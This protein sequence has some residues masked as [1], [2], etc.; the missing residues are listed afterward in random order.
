MNL[1]TKR[2]LLFFR[3]FGRRDHS[4]RRMHAKFAWRLAG[5]ATGQVA[6][7]PDSLIEWWWKVQDL[8]PDER[9]GKP[10]SLEPPDNPQA[11]AAER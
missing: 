9:S 5:I 7:M 8:L 2:V 3:L 10:S 11:K 4:G 6:A 1:Q